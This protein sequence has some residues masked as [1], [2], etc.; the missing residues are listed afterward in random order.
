MA[1]RVLDGDG[2]GSTLTIANGITSRR[3]TAPA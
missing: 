3:T 1:V 2:S